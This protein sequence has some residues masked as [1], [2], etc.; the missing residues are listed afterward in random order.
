MMSSEPAPR[1]IY[2]VTEDWF[3]VSHRLPLAVAAKEAGYDVVVATRSQ[4]STNTIRDAGLRVSH[5]PFKRSG[6]NPLDDLKALTAIVRLYRRERPEIVHHIALKPVVFGTAAARIV[7]VPFVVNA[8]TGL[9]YVF[10]SGDI[11]ARL[12]RPLVRRLLMASLKAPRTR[13]IV[14]NKDDLSFFVRERLARPEDVRLI[15]GSGVDPEKFSKADTQCGSVPNVVLPARMLRDKGVVEFVQAARLLKREGVEANFILCGEPDPEN[16]ASVDQTTIDTWVK[17][18]TVE[19]WGWK[20]DMTPVWQKA[21]IACLPSYREGLPKALLEAGAASLPIVSTDVPGCREI[22]R[23]GE[24]GWLVPARDVKALAEALREAITRKDLR[25]RY[26][27]RSREIVEKELSISVVI[28][29]TLAVYREADS[30]I[31]RGRAAT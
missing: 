13:L 5:V 20:N 19:Y 31:S 30:V 12:L 2:L 26:G 23:P 15:R 18:G 10:S 22:C 29:A 7:R 11:K 3:F 14:Q 25:E 24:N 9:G 28:P 8:L 6:L 1:L 27:N 16:P 21:Q 4:K 17:E